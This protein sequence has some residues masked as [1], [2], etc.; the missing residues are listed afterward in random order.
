[1]IV[2]I[3]TIYLLGA[4]VTFLIDILGW[5]SIY[6]SVKTMPWYCIKDSLI[7]SALW[8]IYWTLIIVNLVLKSLLKILQKNR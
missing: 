3:I 4:N 6:G 1:M 7:M 2:H 8:P 5:I